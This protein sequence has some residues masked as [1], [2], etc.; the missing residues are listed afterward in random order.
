MKEGYTL[1]LA[2]D[3][4]ERDGLGLEL[5]DQAGQM[6]AEIFRDDAT[7][8]TNFTVVAPAASIPLSVLDWFVSRAKADLG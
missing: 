4:Y 5:Y 8:S 3:V 1:V 2:S 7:Q 6:V